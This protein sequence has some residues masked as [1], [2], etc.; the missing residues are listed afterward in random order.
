MSIYKSTL[1]P[2]EA[3][4][5]EIV[6]RHI[7]ISSS[8]NINPKNLKFD[9]VQLHKKKKNYDIRVKYEVVVKNYL[10]NGV[11]QL[12]NYVL[13]V[14]VIHALNNTMLI[15]I[16]YK[17]NEYWQNNYYYLKSDSCV[18]WNMMWYWTMEQL[19]TFI[20]ILSYQYRTGVIV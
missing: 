4:K 14:K 16:E 20:P 9:S 13:D 12:I 15:K 6:M 10:K 8:N 2:H 11:K 5:N 17:C 18:S 19:I 7:A 1:E 3:C